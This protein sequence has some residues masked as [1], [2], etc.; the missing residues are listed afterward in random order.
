MGSINPGFSYQT[1]DPVLVTEG[2]KKFDTGIA[3]VHTNLKNKTAERIG[4]GDGIIGHNEMQVILNNPEEK[5]KF[6]SAI[7][8]E[9]DRY[10]EQANKIIDKDV[11]GIDL[12]DEEI[13]AAS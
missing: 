12:T 5:A 11:N 4:A 9:V 10:E 6:L 2:L 8:S 13:A 3:A 7:I 1:Y